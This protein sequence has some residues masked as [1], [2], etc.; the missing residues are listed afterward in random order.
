MKRVG[1]RQVSLAAIVI[2]C[3]SGPAFAGGFYAPYQSATANA[4]AIAGA[5]AGT[6][7]PSGLFFNPASNASLQGHQIY[8]DAKVFIPDLTLNAAAA[9]TPNTTFNQPLPPNSV[10]DL[11]GEAFAPNVYASYSINE[12]LKL[13]FAFY[14]PFAAKI[15]AEDPTW[16]G[17]YQLTKTDITTYSGTLSLA[18]QL[19]ETLAVGGGVTVEYFDGKFE[20]TEIGPGG[21]DY[22]G[23]LEGDDVEVGFS[24]GLI[25]KPHDGTTIGL[26]YRSQMDHDFNGSAGLRDVVAY[27]AQYDLT[28]PQIVSLG[29]RQKLHSGWTLLGEIEWQDFSTFTGFD[30]ALAPPSPVSRDV[31]PQSWDDSWIFAIGAEYR[32]D[33]KN[34][35]RFGIQYDTAVSDGGG[36]TLSPDADRIMV[37]LGYER[38]VSDRFKWSA[39]YAHVFYDDA[40]I[41]VTP[42]ATNTQGTLIGSMETDLDMFGVSG[43]FTW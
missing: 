29:I 12:R 19:T 22:T 18:Y 4:T 24:A 31:R 25:W 41:N 16:S 20:R 13:G 34:T 17:R 43:T 2:G 40:A 39:F 3:A 37:G 33:E 7:D 10:S 5:T 28:M 8:V 36:N 38:Q 27:G 9:T 23:F 35:W 30:I 1:F 42:S 21:F 15:D 6:G 14:S 32:P 11:A 26:A